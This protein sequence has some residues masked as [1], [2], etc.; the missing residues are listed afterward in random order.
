MLALDV[1]LIH[2]IGLMKS[3]HRPMVQKLYDLRHREVRAF[4]K[5]ALAQILE[6]SPATL[7]SAASESSIGLIVGH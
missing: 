1:D 5:G 3:V 7:A 6:W 4:E 2:I